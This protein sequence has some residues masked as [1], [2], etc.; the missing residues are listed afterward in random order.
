MKTTEDVFTERNNSLTPGLNSDISVDVD[1]RVTARD[2][3][4]AGEIAD[5]IEHAVRRIVNE[6]E[7]Q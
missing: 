5:E 4:T 7:D 6:R 1:V 3:K 2:N